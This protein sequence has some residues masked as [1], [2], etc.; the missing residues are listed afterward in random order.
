[1]IASLD[2]QKA[3]DSISWK[4]ILCALRLFGKGENYIKWIDIIYKNVL[5]CI[6]NNGYITDWFSPSRGTSQG[7]CLSPYH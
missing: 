2:F 4:F 6:S 7:C 1:M 3:F 5:T